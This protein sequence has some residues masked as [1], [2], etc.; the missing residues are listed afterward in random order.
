[1]TGWSTLVATLC[2]IG[3]GAAMVV[4]VLTRR[5][6]RQRAS[7][8]AASVLADPFAQADADAY[9]L[10]GDPRRL[11]PGD[12]VDIRGRSWAVRGSVRLAEG[13]WSWSEHLLD[14]ADG[15]K[16]WLSVEEDPD[17]IVTLWTEVLGATVEPSKDTVDF[18]GRRYRLDEAGKARYTAAGTTGLDPTGTMRYRDYEA[19]DGA[20]LS[21]E[22][23]GDS[24]RWEVARGER[25]HRSELSIY[26]QAS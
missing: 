19:A 2:V 10:R 18:D 9:A 12:L 15:A 22:A 11:K 21:F 23:Y 3:V 25:L 26:P 6:A 20:L 7:G 17:V 14:D 16:R 8:A 13:G 4:F 1:M 5:R 24:P